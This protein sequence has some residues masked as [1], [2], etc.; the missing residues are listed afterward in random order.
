[1]PKQYVVSAKDLA[2]SLSVFTKAARSKCMRFVYWNK[3]K[4]K[5]LKKQL[6]KKWKLMI[7]AT[8]HL[9]KR[10]VILLVGISN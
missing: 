6:M 10:K 5:E 3:T 8:H 2:I 7:I 4:N 9:Q 1:V